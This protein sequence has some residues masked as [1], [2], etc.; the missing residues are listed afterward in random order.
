[1]KLR[2]LAASAAM[3]AVIP[4]A[5][6]GLALPASAA[7]TDQGLS[8][9]LDGRV[10]SDA[11]PQVFG[12]APVLAPGVESTGS[13]WIRNDRE[14]DIEVRIRTIE[15]AASTRIYFETAGATVVRLEPDKAAEFGLRVGLPWSAKN[16][17]ED[18]QVPS[19]Q[20]RIDAVELAG[21]VGQAPDSSRPPDE[22]DSPDS[23]APREELPQSDPPERHDGLGDTG[24]RGAALLAAAGIAGI[25]G[26]SLLAAQRRKQK[27]LETDGVER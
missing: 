14:S 11:P 12:G 23:D 6:L 22:G 25:G 7:E 21:G 17:S 3:T 26:L 5:A 4:C 19:L 16:E 27:E 20:V 2:F 24:F 1:M 13:L 10:Y 8:Y 18:Q 15:P 9:S